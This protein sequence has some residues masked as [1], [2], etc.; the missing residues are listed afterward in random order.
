M[1]DAEYLFKQD[2]REKKIIARSAKNKVRHTGCN[3]P[4]DYMSRKEVEQMN[5]EV[6]IINQD[7][8]RPLTW[9]YFRMLPK[10]DQTSYIQYLL[11][12]FYCTGKQIADKFK[13]NPTYAC[14]YIRQQLP[15]VKLPHGGAYSADR[16]MAGAWEKFWAGEEETKPENASESLQNAPET[17]N[18]ASKGESKVSENA[19]ESDEKAMCETD[20]NQK[21]TTPSLFELFKNARET[22]E[23]IFGL[24]EDKFKDKPESERPFR[25]Q[26]F[27]TTIWDIKDWHD[28]AEALNGFP[29]P[30]HNRITIRIDEIEEDKE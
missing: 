22:F 23:T 25:L 6:Q 14:K 10:E 11:D 13:I 8:H 15:D 20:E 27:S 2:V 24:P 30:E 18:T 21:P 28:L 17:T 4:S 26:N 16:L 3:L 1:D 9:K 19:A 7:L 5:G 29:I 12:T